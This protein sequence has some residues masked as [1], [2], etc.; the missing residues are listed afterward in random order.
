[1]IRLAL[2]LDGLLLP[3]CP[4]FALVSR[5]VDLFPVVVIL[6]FE[7]AGITLVDNDDIC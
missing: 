4:R 5:Y 1:M 6:A 7:T 3:V 2:D